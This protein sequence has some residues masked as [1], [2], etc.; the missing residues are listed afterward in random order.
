MEQGRKKGYI[1]FITKF[2]LCIGGLYHTTLQ[3]RSQ[4][5]S[6]TK[7]VYDIGRDETDFLN[8]TRANLADRK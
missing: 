3:G 1:L 7:L 5:G 2:Q 8:K 6:E 4:M